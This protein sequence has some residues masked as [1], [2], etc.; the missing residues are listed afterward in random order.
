MPLKRKPIKSLLIVAALLASP[1]ATPAAMP[2]AAA[3]A[4]Q[5]THSFSDVSPTFWAYKEIEE[6]TSLGALEGY[7]NGR[8]YPNNLLTRAQGAKVLDQLT[9][10]QAAPGSFKP[11]F[12]DVTPNHWAYPFVRDLTYDGV[13]LNTDRFRPQENLSRAQMAKIIVEAFDI[14]VDDNDLA[15]FVDTPAG[16]FH[17]Y[18]TTIGEL[19]ITTGRPGARFDPNGPVTRAQFATFASRAL[20]FDEKRRSGQIVYDK[21]DKLYVDLT[22][23]PL[24]LSNPAEQVGKESITLVNKERQNRHLPALKEDTNL[25]AMAQLKAEEMAEKGYF[26]HDSPTY[27]HVNEM[28]AMFGYSFTRIGENI[29]WNQRSPEEVTADWMASPGHRKNILDPRYT[30]VGAGFATNSQGE[31]YWVHIFAKK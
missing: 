16:E 9:H 30:N 12:K 7:P 18:I 13:F 31:T 8:F 28:A 10:A 26:S 15:H 21:E 25:D 17:G 2:A 27:G 1:A 14:V 19:G 22:G 29:A 20:A 3:Q 5:A 11:K 4:A 6:L 23:E 24:A